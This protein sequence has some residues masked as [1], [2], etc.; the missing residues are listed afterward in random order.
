MDVLVADVGL[1]RNAAS[2]AVGDP[3]VQA[4]C[5]VDD[6]RVTGIQR[7]SSL[8][9]ARMPKVPQHHMVCSPYIKDA[10]LG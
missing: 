2:E 3:I 10:P 9:Y 5:A 6:G 4:R 8:A 7:C 1:P